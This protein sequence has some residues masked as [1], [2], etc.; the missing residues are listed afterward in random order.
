MIAMN[1]LPPTEEPVPQT[2]N[3]LM[4]CTLKDYQEECVEEGTFPSDPATEVREW[5]EKDLDQMEANLNNLLYQACPF[6]PHQFIHCVKPQTEFG[7][8]RYKC[9]QEGCPVYLFGD[10]RDIMLDKL[11][12][13]NHSQV[14]AQSQR[15]LLKGKCGFTPKMKLRSTTRNY[16]KVFLSCGNVLPWREP[17]GYFQW[18]HGPLWRPREQA[19]PSLRRWGY[20]HVPSPS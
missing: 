10:T 14:R 20:G 8:L 18:L 16:N 6:H 12:E 2:V 1:A 15:G 9:P 3:E 7:Q 11:K 17:C 4:D 19:Q 13:K 5:K